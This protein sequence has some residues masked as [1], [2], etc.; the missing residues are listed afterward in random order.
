M[1][2]SALLIGLNFSNLLPKN[3]NY[4]FNFVTFESTFSAVHYYQ[5]D[6]WVGWW[7]VIKSIL[8][9]YFILNTVGIMLM[10]PPDWG[11]LGNLKKGGGGYVFN[12]VIKL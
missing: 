1:N 2:A 7:T 6:G 11:M 5:M 8:E 10:L 4:G 3:E 12:G 9:F